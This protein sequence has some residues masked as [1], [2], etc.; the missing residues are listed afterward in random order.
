MLRSMTNDDDALRCPRCAVPLQETRIDDNCIE[1]CDVCGGAWVDHDTLAR[2]GSDVS[3]AK[4]LAS[5]VAIRGR[6]RVLDSTPIACPVC[7]TALRRARVEGTGVDVDYCAAHGTWL[8]WGEIVPFV[9]A[10]ADDPPRAYT[11]DELEAAALPNK[12]S[13]GFFGRVKRL[14]QRG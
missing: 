11:V 2:L 12:P 7:S 3:D 10:D 14:V 5:R 6:A 13:V 9:I 1:G 8:D 4:V